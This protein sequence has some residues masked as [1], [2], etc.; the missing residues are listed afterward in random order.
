MKKKNR[1]V[2]SDKGRERALVLLL[3][4]VD[5]VL[6]G[7]LVDFNWLNGYLIVKKI[8]KNKEYEILKIWV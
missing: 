6:I 4:T 8:I 7:R 5:I 3:V 1:C 2:V